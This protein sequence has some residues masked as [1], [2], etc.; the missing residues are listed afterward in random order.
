[1]ACSERLACR[2]LG[3]GRST[4][5]KMKQHEPTDRAI[6]HLPLADAIAN[7]HARSRGAY[8]TL[9][10]RAPPE[11]EQ[12][13]SSTRGRSGRSRANRACTVCPGRGRA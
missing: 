10:V 1:M 3:L 13:S 5:H 2:V 9:R 12:G 11:T 4:Y 8:D 7:I 6:C